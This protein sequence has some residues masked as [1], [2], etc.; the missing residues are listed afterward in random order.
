MAIESA[1]LIFRNKQKR[2]EVDLS[3]FVF[4]ISCRSEN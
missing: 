3:P 1:A 2:T 4:E